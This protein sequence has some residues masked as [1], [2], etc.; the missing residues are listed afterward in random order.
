MGLRLDRRFG[1]LMTSL[2]PPRGSGHLGDGIEDYSLNTLNLT[3]CRRRRWI[4]S[5]FSMGEG[6]RRVRGV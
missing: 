3:Y 5:R 2:L 6:M 1:P 4:S